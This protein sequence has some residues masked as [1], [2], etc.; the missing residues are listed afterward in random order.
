VWRARPGRGSQRGGRARSRNVGHH[1]PAMTW[2]IAPLTDDFEA[3]AA[4]LNE[5]LGARSYTAR[6][7]AREAVDPAILVLGLR[8]ADGQLLGVASA[9]LLSAEGLAF[10]HAFGDGVRVLEGRRVGSLYTS[11][12]VPA[13]RGRGLGSALARAR[14]SW[15]RDQGSEVAIVAVGPSSHVAARLRATRVCGARTL[16]GPLHTLERPARLRLPDLR[17]PLPLSSPALRTGRGRR[18]LGALTSRLAA[19]RATALAPRCSAPP[20]HR[21]PCARRPARDGRERA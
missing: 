19:L 13:Q 2:T 14:L 3:A 12:V 17:A 18:A 5:A 11:A 10:Y 8:A 1:G 7:L 15:L 20:A 6:T 4:L 9:Q 21:G 16:R